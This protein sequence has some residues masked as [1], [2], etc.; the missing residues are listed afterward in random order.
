MRRKHSETTTP[1]SSR[2]R[3]RQRPD[4]P[5][6]FSYNRVLPGILNYEGRV[7][8]EMH[9]RTANRRTLP[10]NVV[11]EIDSYF[12]RSDYPV[13]SHMT[14]PTYFG[15]EEQDPTPASRKPHKYPAA[16]FFSGGD[17][18]DSAVDYSHPAYVEIVS[19]HEGLDQQY[20]YPFPS[21][22]YSQSWET[23]RPRMYGSTVPI[24]RLNEPR[25]EPDSAEE[26]RMYQRMMEDARRNRR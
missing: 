21:N 2:R 8:P 13:G 25:L 12:D 17:G 9:A 10:A 4:L 11:S 20:G 6:G 19:G 16:G 3:Q 24:P 26:Y 23:R 22:Y 5:S 14:V 15:P 7:L 18:D 1:L